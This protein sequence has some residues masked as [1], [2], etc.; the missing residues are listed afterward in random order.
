MKR[1]TEERMPAEQIDVN[2]NLTRLK[3]IHANWMIE[4]YDFLTSEEGKMIHF[5]WL[6]NIRD[7]GSG[8]KTE[9]LPI[10]DP[11]MEHLYTQKRLLQ[12]YET[13]TFSSKIVCFIFGQICHFSFANFKLSFAKLRLRE[14]C[15][16][17]FSLKL[18]NAKTVGQG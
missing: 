9:T 1:K 14:I 3:H 5:K 2:F 13:A 15:T 11:F 10:K 7:Y 17:R 16:H 12:R 18:N 6:E 4:M 8:K